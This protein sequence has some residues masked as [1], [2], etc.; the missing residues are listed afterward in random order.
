MMQNYADDTK[1]SNNKIL[2]F[3]LQK[4]LFKK[5]LSNVNLN[6]NTF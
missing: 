2:H 6:V 3:I 1:S 5:N 4:P